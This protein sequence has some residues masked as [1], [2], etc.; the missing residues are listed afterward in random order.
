[1]ARRLFG[2][3]IMTT[4]LPKTFNEIPHKARNHRKNGGC[5]LFCL[6]IKLHIAINLPEEN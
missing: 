4:P 5:G 2:R 6:A 3:D 1:M